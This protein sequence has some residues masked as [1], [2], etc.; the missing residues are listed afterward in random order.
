MIRPGYRL[1]DG[2]EMLLPIFLGPGQSVASGLTG[3]QTMAA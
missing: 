3:F 2:N 1:N